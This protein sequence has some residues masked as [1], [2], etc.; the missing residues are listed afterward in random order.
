M[1]GTR[2]AAAGKAE[3]EPTVTEVQPATA[4]AEAPAAAEAAEVR[5]CCIHFARVWRTRY[6]PQASA[7][8]E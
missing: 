5:S 6:A 4:A 7:L 1:V 3:P 8:A 2:S